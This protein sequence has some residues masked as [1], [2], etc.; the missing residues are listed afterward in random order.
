MT[1]SGLVAINDSV[2]KLAYYDATGQLVTQAQLQDRVIKH[3]I[4]ET[5]TQLYAVVFGLD[6][7]G[8]PY[9]LAQNI[10][11]GTKDLFYE[12]YQVRLNWV[13]FYRYLPIFVFRYMIFSTNT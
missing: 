9:G 12:P 5:L 7:L 11:E 3:Y 4:H 8:N 2:L 1:L 10:K 13:W 6:I